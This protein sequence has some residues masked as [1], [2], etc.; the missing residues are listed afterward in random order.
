MLDGK[1]YYA[2]FPDDDPALPPRVRAVLDALR[3]LDKAFR[4]HFEAFRPR[5]VSIGSLGPADPS[6]CDV[7][8][9]AEAAPSLRTAGWVLS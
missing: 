4:L 5:A 2:A 9:L 3:K 7:E 6:E 8:H 1:R